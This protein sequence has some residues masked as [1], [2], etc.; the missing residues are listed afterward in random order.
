MASRM[1]CVT[2]L[3]NGETDPPLN[4][5]SLATGRGAY[6]CPLEGTCI[7]EMVNNPRTKRLEWSSGGRGCLEKGSISR[8]SANGVKTWTR[9]EAITRRNGI[10]Q[11][12]QPRSTWH[13]SQKQPTESL[14]SQSE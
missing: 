1:P 12:D 7:N 5:S 10:C 3:W 13:C 14:V 6:G 8:T 2:N 9:H 4:Q 11:G